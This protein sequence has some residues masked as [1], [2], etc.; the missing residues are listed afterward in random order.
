M[1]T[2][3]SLVVAQYNRG[4]HF[5]DDNYFR[6]LVDDASNIPGKYLSTKNEKETLKELFEEHLDLYFDWANIQ[7]LDF[8]KHMINE[9]EVVYCCKFFNI[10]GANKKG[11][12]VTPKSN[13]NLEPYYEELF[14]RRVR[15]GFIN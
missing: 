1:K 14:A 2:K 11:R 10:H 5:S 4:V 6:F 15:P 8:R 7:L 3:I 9:C 12:F 13:I